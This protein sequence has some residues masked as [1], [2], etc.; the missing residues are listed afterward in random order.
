MNTLSIEK[1][2][3]AT[4][5]SEYTKNAISF[6]LSLAKLLGARVYALSVLEHP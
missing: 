3:I 5:G 6:G 4:D 1:I 2:V